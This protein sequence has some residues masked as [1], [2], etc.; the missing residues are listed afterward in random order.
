MQSAV[1]SKQQLLPKAKTGALANIALIVGSLALAW[2]CAEVFCRMVGFDFE[3][4]HAAMQR[5]PVFFRKATVPLEPVFFRRP[6][7]DQWSGK[8]L[9]VGYSYWRAFEN[10]YIDEPSRT[11][12]YDRDGFR[13]PPDLQD[14]HLVVAGDSF[15]ELGYLPYKSLLSTVIGRE[16][17]LRVRNLGVSLNGPYAYAAYLKHFG[18]SPAGRHAVAVFYEGNDLDDLMR[19]KSDLTAFQTT[20]QRP[21]RVFETQTSLTRAAWRI[22]KNIARRYFGESLANADFASGDRLVPVTLTYTP[23]APSKLTAEQREALAEAFAQWAHYARELEMKPWLVFM[24]SKERVLHDRVK[25]RS[26][27]SRQIREWQTNDL[28]RFVGA[29]AEGLGITFIDLTPAF[30]S[31]A[32]RG[33]LLY[34]GVYDTHLTEEGSVLAGRWIAQEMKRRL[35]GSEQSGLQQNSE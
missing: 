10:A 6:G 9:Q 27:A 29:S 30:Q 7:P 20:G 5:M 34:N 17:G 4:Q 28:P 3:R 8:V 12:E 21:Y 13:N 35:N 32:A 19:E 14:W 1:D 26:N 23:P 18:R 25:L 24:P 2:G 31:E 22:S 33:K 16:L 15:V 11:I